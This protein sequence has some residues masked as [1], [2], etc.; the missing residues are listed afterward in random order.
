MWFRTNFF[1][2]LTPLNIHSEEIHNF[3]YN[4]PLMS[5]SKYICGCMKV[6]TEY[7]ANLFQINQGLIDEQNFYNRILEKLNYSKRYD[8][9]MSFTKMSASIVE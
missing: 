5:K 4:T 1:H 7:F 8:D 2:T 9:T 6:Q 3:E